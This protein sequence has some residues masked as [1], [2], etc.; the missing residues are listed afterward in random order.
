MTSTK[1][2][3]L[4]VGFSKPF[5]KSLSN[6]F[7]GGIGSRILTFLS[8]KSRFKVMRVNT[9]RTTPNFCKN[10]KNA[11]E[12]HPKGYFDDELYASILLRDVIV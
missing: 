11:M 2:N 8:F 3:D 9:L 4:T 12:I 1:S 6:K 10:T 5:Q 7:A